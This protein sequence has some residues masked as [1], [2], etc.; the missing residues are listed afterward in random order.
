MTLQNYTTNNTYSISNFSSCGSGEVCGSTTSVSSNLIV[1]TI[2]SSALTEVQMNSIDPTMFLCDGRSCVG[3]NYQTI[4]GNTTVPD[5]RLNFLRGYDNTIIDGNPATF[6]GS[7]NYKT[8]RPTT[9]VLSGV[10]AA[11]GSEHV[12]TGTTNSYTHAHTEGIYLGGT[13]FDAEFGTVTTTNPNPQNRIMGNANENSITHP[14]TSNDTHSHTIQTGQGQGSHAH[15]VDI[16][17]G[18][19]DETRPQNVLVNYFI[20]V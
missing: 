16:T 10:A 8:A 1:G 5:L 2:I 17:G 11:A 18:G 3:T 15:N 7:Y 19:D 6:L 12:H 9:T 20:K 14:R 4:T 13:A